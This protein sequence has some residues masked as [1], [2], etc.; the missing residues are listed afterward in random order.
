MITKLKLYTRI[1]CCSILLMS[2]SSQGPLK[3]RVISYN[4]YTPR[5]ERQP[6]GQPAIVRVTIGL[7]E[8]R[9]IM[10]V[11]QSEWIEVEIVS[12]TLAGLS[13]GQRLQILTLQ[14]PIDKFLITGRTLAV[15]EKDNGDIRFIEDYGSSAKEH[16]H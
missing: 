13:S 16:A 15:Y 7:P 11:A 2:C 14:S 5:N 6:T 1:A 12:G 3:Q 4:P 8:I 9:A 10:S